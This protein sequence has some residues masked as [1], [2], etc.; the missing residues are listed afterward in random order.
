MVCRDLSCYGCVKQAIGRIAPEL[1]NFTA[2]EKVDFSNQFM[3]GPLP[4][5]WSL[6]N[7]M[8]EMKTL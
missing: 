8:Q 1:G 7:A 4:D 5:S 3:T 2:L 6:S